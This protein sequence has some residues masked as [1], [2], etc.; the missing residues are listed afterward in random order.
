[1]VGQTDITKLIAT[2]HNFANAPKNI[3]NND[4][5]KNS[6]LDLSSA[7]LDKLLTRTRDQKQHALTVRRVLLLV[8]FYRN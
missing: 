7:Y 2:F 3:Y 8:T 5:R 1:M 4:I 6:L